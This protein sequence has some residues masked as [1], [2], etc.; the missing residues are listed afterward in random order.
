MLVLVVV[1]YFQR[2]SK[3]G[4]VTT[5]LAPSASQF[6][7]DFGAK[8][9][10]L[11][12]EI[13]ALR[14]QKEA[15]EAEI[16]ATIE[17][18]P[19]TPKRDFDL[20]FMHIPKTGGTT[21]EDVLFKKYNISVGKRYSE[22]QSVP[23]CGCNRWHCPLSE[24]RKQSAYHRNNHFFT[25]IRD[26]FARYLSAYTFCLNGGVYHQCWHHVLDAIGFTANVTD[27]LWFCETR[28]FNHITALLLK[29]L[30]NGTIYRHF[31][32]C[33]FMPQ[34][35]YVYL[36]GTK[37]V[38]HVL[39]FESFAADVLRLFKS[40][41]DTQSV[42]EVDLN[43]T[44]RWPHKICSLSMRDINETNRHLLKTYYHA[45]FTHFYPQL[46]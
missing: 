31:R 28:H 46:L 17:F 18:L 4:A 3:L 38:R 15:L 42:T 12:G 23:G 13:A 8:F 30:L 2:F 40:F 35:F 44:K 19:A 29:G 27:K 25:V 45:D 7:E 21:I 43:G 41:N 9:E 36:N 33:H 34:H 6:E 24:K 26:P 37:M 16:D 32:D 5:E 11:R 1:L 20:Q 10:V 39:R 22:W 14:E